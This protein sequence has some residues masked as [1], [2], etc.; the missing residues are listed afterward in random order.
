VGFA[1]KYIAMGFAYVPNRLGL[2]MIEDP[3]ANALRAVVYDCARAL[4]LPRE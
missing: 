3:R 2:H 4:Y 1:D